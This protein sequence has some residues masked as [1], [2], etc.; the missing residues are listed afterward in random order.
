[1]N[2]LTG[3]PRLVRL[4]LRRDRVTLP[5]WLLGLT[6]FVAVTTTMFN[7]SLVTQ[8]DLVRE[9][10]LVTTNAGMRM[11]GLASG[12]TVGGYMLHRE[13]VTLA[14]LAAL[15]SI[16]AVV[17][18]TRQNE[19]L[20]RSE[21]VGS[22]VVGRYAALGAAVLV[23]VLAD[24][25]LALGLGLAILATGQ[26]AAGSLLAGVA[27]GGVG[28]AF[29]GVAAVTCQLVSTTR[30]AAGMA[31]AVLGLA[32]VV[33]GIGNMT[34]TVD[35]AGLR[36]ASS[37][38]VW[39][40]PI[41]WGQQMRPFADDL[42]WPVALFAVLFVALVALAVAL[43]GRRDLGRGLWPEH[44][45]HAHAASALLSPAGLTWRLQRATFLGW[46]AALL[47]FGMV[48]GTLSEQIQD[49]TGPAAEYYRQM[50]GSD[51]VLDGYRTSIMA[52][53]GMFVT[54]YVVQVLQR[55]RVDEAG[56]T[57]ESLLATAVTRPAWVA[58]HVVNAVAGALALLLLFAVAMG[59]SAGLVLGDSLSQVGEMAVAGLAQLPGI[60]VVAAVVLA[61]VGLVPRWSGPLSWLV[62]VLTLL[63]GPMFA[64][65]LGLPAWLQ[66]LSPFTHTPKV[67]AGALDPA[68]L[69]LLLAVAVTLG[70]AGLAATRRRS[71]VLPA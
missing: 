71:L 62:L 58:G 57:L 5:A 24:V 69:V 55:M 23:G 40:S 64:P 63:L 52:M 13:Y 27:V 70:A 9:T 51:V 26:P 48:F 7:H 43:N 1:M 47:G 16:L 18:H 65:A 46:A 11:L 35:A 22:A 33:S 56:G 28:L 60:L 14:A 67:P 36:V 37:W 61:L 59:W 39:L 4:A 45:G 29:V 30:G 15:M 12:P 44:R 41:G 38:P 6:V 34:G 21:V 50:G 2:G 17:R 53:A 10:R 19:E 3:T 54:V 8:A 25:L 42:A 20:G 31:G 66:D 32:F 49:V 68:P